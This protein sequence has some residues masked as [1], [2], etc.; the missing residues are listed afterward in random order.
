LLIQIGMT[1]FA[2]RQSEAAR[3]HLREGNDHV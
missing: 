3:V 2:L 1:R